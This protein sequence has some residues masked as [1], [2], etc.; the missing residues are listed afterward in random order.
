VG[1]GYTLRATSGALTAN[2]SSAFNITSGTPPPI[3]V[4]TTLSTGFF[5][6]R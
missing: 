2:T 6:R 3:L 5:L 4:N 1:L